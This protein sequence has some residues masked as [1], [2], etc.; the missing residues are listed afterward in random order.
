M[1][2]LTYLDGSRHPLHTIYCIGRNYAAHIEELG[3][4]RPAHPVV[5]LKPQSALS[6][7]AAVALPAFSQDVHYE[8]E[9]VVHIGRGGKNIAREQ[10]LEHIAGYALG[11]DLTARDLQQHAQQNG[12]PWTLAKGF[13]HA[14]VLTAFVPADGHDPRHIRFS[15]TLNGE[16]RQNGDTA[17]MLFPVADII[18]YLSHHFTLHTGDI[19]YTGT[20]QGVGKLASGDR[21][22]LTLEDTALAADFHII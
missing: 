15:M 16:A 17:L 13:D 20:P 11:L 3:N 19:I 9:L 10:A 21:I 18:E 4:V 6:T 22:R 8:T 7:E 12:L 14:A 1:S 2:Q 5:F